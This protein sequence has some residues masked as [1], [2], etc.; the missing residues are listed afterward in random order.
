MVQDYLAL[1]QKRLRSKTLDEN[2]FLLP[3]FSDNKSALL[4]QFITDHL[5]LLKEYALIKEESGSKNPYQYELEKK[6]DNLDKKV[7]ELL[8]KISEDET[9]KNIR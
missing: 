6:I 8:N 9:R 3:A 5:L 7:T 4:Q 1:I 2:D